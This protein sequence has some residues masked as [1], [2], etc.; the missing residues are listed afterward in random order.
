MILK[1][2]DKD[3]GQDNKN[4]NKNFLI[5]IGIEKHKNPKNA[6]QFSVCCLK[7]DPESGI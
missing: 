1:G 5:T 2:V 6:A 4:R 7:Y 3:Q